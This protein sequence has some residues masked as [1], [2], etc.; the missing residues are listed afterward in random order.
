VLQQVASEFEQ[1]FASDGRISNMTRIMAFHPEF[2]KVAHSLVSST[3]LFHQS[4]N[5]MTTCNPAGI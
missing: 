2:L 5:L 3:S 1:A 4:L